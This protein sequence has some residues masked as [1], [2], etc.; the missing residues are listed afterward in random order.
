[1]IDHFYHLDFDRQRGLQEQLRESLVSAILGGGFPADEPLP[2]C[3]KLSQQLSVSR[4]TVAL[5]Y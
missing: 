4:N 1:M 2:S 5:V 3:R